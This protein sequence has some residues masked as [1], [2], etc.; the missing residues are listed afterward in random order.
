M[1]WYDKQPK[2]GPTLLQKYC[3]P[4]ILRQR[5]VFMIGGSKTYQTKSGKTYAYLVPIVDR[6]MQSNSV[7]KEVILEN[8]N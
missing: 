6:M 2:A 7:Y 4:S 3:W 8:R 1:P 5:N